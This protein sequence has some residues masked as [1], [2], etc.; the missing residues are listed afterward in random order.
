M[1][2]EVLHA[3]T[4]T[5]S[6]VLSWNLRLEPR[7]NWPRTALLA[8][9]CIT[10][11]YLTRIVLFNLSNIMMLLRYHLGTYSRICHWPTYIDIHGIYLVTHAVDFNAAR[12]SYIV[13]PS[14][15]KQP[16]LFIWKHTHT[17]HLIIAV[18]LN[19]SSQTTRQLLPACFRFSL[20]IIIDPAYR[21]V[22][23]SSTI[24]GIFNSQDHGWRHTYF[25]PS[26]VI[27]HDKCQLPGFSPVSDG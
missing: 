20:A 14:H 3:G 22:A 12:V 18:H 8:R 15:H 27:T 2:M 10:V 25:H 1:C 9:Y 4:S 26:R 5:H 6:K 13:R 16:T 17:Y 21:E 19:C 11:P 24:S 7:S 23:M